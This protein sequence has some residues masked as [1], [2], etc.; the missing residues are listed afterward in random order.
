MNE[1]RL[2]LSWS[3]VEKALNEGTFSGYKIG[4]LET[5]KLFKDFLKQKNIPGQN[6]SRQIK[7][8]KRFLSL[9]DKLSY[10]WHT[11]QRIILEPD[12]E[13]NREETK[14]II[15]GYWQAM[16]DIEEAVESLNSWEKIS[17]RFKYFLSI[18]IKKMRW[19]VGA[20]FA[21]VALIWFLSETLWGQTAS[22]A[23]LIANHF[24]IF[25]ILYWTA[26]IIIGLAV[27]M[28]ILYFILK[29]KSRF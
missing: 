29:Q 3:A 11:C 22:R 1:N 4:I 7:Y 5:E 25:Q 24:F 27:L 16:I 8:V 17:L 6:I 12:F 19:F 14:Q 26:I 28:G 9:P 2:N 20:F 13:I 18:V 23:I 15:S 10:S 21:L